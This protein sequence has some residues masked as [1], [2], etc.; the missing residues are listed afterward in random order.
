MKI[1]RNILTLIFVEFSI[2]SQILNQ[3][4]I[5]LVYSGPLHP[6][7]YIYIYIYI[8]IYRERERERESEGE[9]ERE[10]LCVDSGI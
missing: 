6:I 5:E 9:R 8:Y 3:C 7:S 1:L 10:L 4:L 2:F